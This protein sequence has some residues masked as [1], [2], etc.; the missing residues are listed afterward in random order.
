MEDLLARTLGPMIKLDK[1][2]N[3]NPAPVLADA[4]Q[5]EMMI[6]NLAINARDAMPDGGSLTV[7]TS[8][9]ALKGDPE[10]ADGDYIELAVRDSGTGM[11]EDTLRRAMEPFF[12]TKP[13][14]KGTGL[15][16][17]QIYG[18]ARQA[19][20]TVR[21][22]SEVGVGTAV[23]VYLPCTDEAPLRIDGEAP[24]EKEGQALPPLHIL[25]VDDDDHLRCVLAEGLTDLGHTVSTASNGAEALS[26]LETEEPQ[27]AVV[28]FA[29]PD[30]NGA[31]LAQQMAA[32]LPGLPI[33]FVSGYADTAAIKNTAGENVLILQ[34]PFNLDRLTASL[35]Q[36]GARAAG[37]GSHA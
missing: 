8:K 11:D 36:V 7:S 9:H 1:E 33:I 35:K 21:I 18:S 17:A 26:L 28:D 2:L 24:G 37:S 25:L 34:K 23:R 19:G 32:R 16:L 20:S 27:V 4:T 13:Q 29:M 14:G 3:P 30:M 22:E 5:V 15:G 12:T 10:L 6:L 31:V